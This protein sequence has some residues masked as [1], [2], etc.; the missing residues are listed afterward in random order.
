LQQA[1]CH[2]IKSCGLEHHTFEVQQHVERQPLDTLPIE[3]YLVHDTPM[4]TAHGRVKQDDAGYCSS[5]V[6]R[7]RSKGSLRV[8][9]RDSPKVRH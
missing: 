8:T 9:W 5:V 7:P 2:F 1:Q 6:L 4:V 3:E